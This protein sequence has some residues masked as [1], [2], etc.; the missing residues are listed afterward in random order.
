VYLHDQ[1]RPEGSHTRDAN[2][3]L[4]RAVG[5]ADGCKMCSV[6]ARKTER[7]ISSGLSYGGSVHPKTMAAA[8]PPCR[9]LFVSI[10]PAPSNEDDG[11]VS[12]ETHHPNKG[13][14]LGRVLGLVHLGLVCG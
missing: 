14:K 7:S 10:E 4:G 11:I 2:S 9:A 13:R 1:L 3:R 12:S 5:S 6:F 8:I